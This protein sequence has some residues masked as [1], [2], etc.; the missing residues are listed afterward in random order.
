MSLWGREMDFGPSLFFFHSLFNFLLLAS[1]IKSKEQNHQTNSRRKIVIMEK[2]KL[3]MIAHMVTASY[4]CV[5]IELAVTNS[6][7]VEGSFNSRR[8]RRIEQRQWC[9]C[10]LLV[11]VAL[12]RAI[13]CRWWWGLV[14]WLLVNPVMWSTAEPMLYL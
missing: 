8:R 5:F 14:R 2:C 7:V 3:P 4:R 9:W 6:T 1:E 11:V 12:V 13:W 10:S